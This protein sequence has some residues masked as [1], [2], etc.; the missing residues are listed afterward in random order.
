MKKINLPVLLVMKLE[1][2][3]RLYSDPLNLET[4]RPLWNNISVGTPITPYWVFT[5]NR[6]K[7][8]AEVST[9]FLVLVLK[10]IIRC[11]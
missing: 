6:K 1:K 3:S 8:S 9:V 2:L 7:K 5:L 4:A 11:N 10:E